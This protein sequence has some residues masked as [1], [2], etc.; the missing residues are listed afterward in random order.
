MFV[1]ETIAN[2]KYLFVGFYL[3]FDHGAKVVIPKKDA[4][5]SFLHSGGELT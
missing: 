4:E 2:I 5:F 3:E 1:S